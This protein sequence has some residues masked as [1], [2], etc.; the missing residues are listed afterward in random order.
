MAAESPLGP[1]PTTTA[2]YARLGLAKRSTLAVQRAHLRLERLSVAAI[3]RPCRLLPLEGEP[4]LDGRLSRSISAS[5]SRRHRVQP[6]LRL[7]DGETSG[8]V[9][10]ERG[11][12]QPR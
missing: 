3:F 9:E 8:G 4:P 7:D 2:S 12:A 1:A 5:E 10:Q 11:R 6:V